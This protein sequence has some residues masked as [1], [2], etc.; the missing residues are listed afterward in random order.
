MISRLERGLR[1]P[2]ASTLGWLSWGIVGP[3]NADAVKMRLC[4][5]AGIG[6]TAESRWS[7]RGHRGAPG[8]G[9]RRA[10]WSCPAGCSRRNAMNIV[11]T[12]APEHLGEARKVQEMAR[13]GNVPW[14]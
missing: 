6:L 8:G 10:V 13:A 1:R 3:D 11:G 4:A 12:V 9:S 5:T 2:R 7:E 14:P